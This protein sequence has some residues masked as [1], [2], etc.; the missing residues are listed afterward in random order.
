MADWLRPGQRTIP[1]VTVARIAVF[2]GCPYFIVRVLLAPA[3]QV[4]A[5]ATWQFMTCH[6]SEMTVITH[7]Y[8]R[9]YHSTRPRMLFTTRFFFFFF[10]IFALPGF[11]SEAPMIERSVSKHISLARNYVW[12][13]ALVSHKQRMNKQWRSLVPSAWGDALSNSR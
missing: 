7:L 10:H 8:S 6:N 13:S 12:F 5:T 9:D 1:A 3:S 11:S 4:T 2:H